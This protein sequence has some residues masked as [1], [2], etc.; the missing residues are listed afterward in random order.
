MRTR[1]RLDDAEA[2]A[3]AATPGSTGSGS[4]GVRWQ[5]AARLAA[6]ADAILE[7]ALTGDSQR[8]L[9]ANQQHGGE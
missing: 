1:N 2:P 9:E 3:G 5:E 8:F 4:G 6:E 7:R